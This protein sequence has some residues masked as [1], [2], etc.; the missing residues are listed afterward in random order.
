MNKAIPARYL[1]I[2]G[3]LLLASNY[4]IGGAIGSLLAVLGLLL[5]LFGV[6]GLFRKRR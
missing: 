4:V 5:F 3:A 1:L 2:F 6:A